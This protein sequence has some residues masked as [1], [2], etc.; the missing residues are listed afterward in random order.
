MRTHIVFVAHLLAAAL[1]WPA[2]AAPLLRCTL[3][4]AGQT[5]VVQAHP[6]ANPYTVAPV[7]LGESFRFKAV[8]VGSASQI[9]YI[10]LYTY[11]SQAEQFVLLHQVSYT[12]PR[13][14]AEAAGPHALTGLHRVYSPKLGRELIYG[15]TL[16]E[17]AEGAKG[18]EVQP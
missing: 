3:E 5:Y 2:Q 12:A 1:A 18:T 9:H 7:A 10:K 4:R 6:V 8:M 16:L 14:S 17:D 13:P 15:C 11:A